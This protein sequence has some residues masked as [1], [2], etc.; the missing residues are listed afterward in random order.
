MPTGRWYFPLTRVEQTDDNGCGIACVATTCG[1]TYERAR[2][3]FFPRRR[4]FR[5]DKKLHV[6]GHAM[7]GAIRRLGFSAVWK[8]TYKAATS[9]VILVFSWLPY[10]GMGMNHGVVW[11]PYEKRIID[12]GYDHDYGHKPDF[13][14]NLWKRSGYSALHITGKSF[15]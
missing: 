3:E 1:V 15:R 10:N 13:Y 12:P 7:V 9:P 14:F 11:D 5:D 8:K 4:K 6:D 2:F